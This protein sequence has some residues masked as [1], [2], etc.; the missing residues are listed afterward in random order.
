MNVVDVWVC[1]GVEFGLVE[2][3]LY[4]DMLRYVSEGVRVLDVGGFVH[5]NFEIIL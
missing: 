3:V 5:F 4:F 2:V 1:F